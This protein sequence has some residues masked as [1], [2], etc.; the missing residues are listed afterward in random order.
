MEIC[1][2]RDGKSF[3]VAEVRSL[4]AVTRIVFALAFDFVCDG[5]SLFP[6]PLSGGRLSPADRLIEGRL[7]EALR[8]RFTET[9]RQSSD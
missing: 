5:N 2:I 7:T 6:C 1:V 3:G 8:K 4:V 9:C